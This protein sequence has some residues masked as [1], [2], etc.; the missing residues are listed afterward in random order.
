MSAEIMDQE[1]L[2]RQE[3][4]QLAEDFLERAHY[5]ADYEEF[6]REIF[7]HYDQ[8]LNKNYHELNMMERDAAVLVAQINHFEAKL[9]INAF[10]DLAAARHVE[11]IALLAEAKKNLT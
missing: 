6:Y 7:K 3:K 10:L 11:N 5:D 2:S 9:E 1:G 8:K 4:N